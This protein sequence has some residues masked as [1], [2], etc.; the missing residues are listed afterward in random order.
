MDIDVVL[1][2]EEIAA[3]L[4]EATPVRIHLTE[5]DEDR[6]WVELERPTEVSLVPNLGVRI[7]SSGRIRYELAGIK[8][9]FS[10]RRLQLLCEPRVVSGAGGQE[11]L[12]FK[13]SVEQADLENVPS[14]ADRALVTAVNDAL[15][16]A[17]LGMFW[18]FGRMLYKSLRMPERYEPL[19]QFNVRA[20]AGQVIVGATELRF[21]LQLGLGFSRNRARPGDD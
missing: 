6:R 18:N 2:T 12:D 7:V 15:A 17:R 3:L 16:P 4:K 19:N 5:R 1:S 13:L 21:R 20:P 8:L 14:L 11:R 10:I 9:P